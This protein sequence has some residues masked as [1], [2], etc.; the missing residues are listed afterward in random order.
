MTHESSGATSAVLGRDK[1][2]LV[3][4]VGLQRAGKN[5]MV[6]LIP[7]LSISIRVMPDGRF[8]WRTRIRQS[9]KLSSC[10][11]RIAMVTQENILFYDTVLHK[12]LFR[13]RV[14]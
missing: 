3:S 12:S 2:E 8:A 10:A 9:E 1:G 4:L 5:D 13:G 7:R 14:T 6:N 11:G